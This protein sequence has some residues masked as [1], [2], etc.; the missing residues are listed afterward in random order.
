MNGINTLMEDLHNKL[1]KDINS[2]QLPVG[3]IYYVA[4]DVFKEIEMG[5][6]KQL[7][8]EKQQDEIEKDQEEKDEIQENQE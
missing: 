6:E 2:C 7:I 1:I 8:I 5:Y 4:K 3:I